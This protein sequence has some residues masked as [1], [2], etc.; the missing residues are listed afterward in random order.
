M[1]NTVN[2]ISAVD[3]EKFMDD[4]K[5]V[6]ERTEAELARTVR[7]DGV[8]AA[9]QV[10]FDIVDPTEEAEERTRD[11]KLPVSQLGLDRA[12]AFLKE[13]HKK[14]GITD[15]DAFVSNPNVRKQ[16]ASKSVISINKARDRLIYNAA[17][18]APN[19]FNGGASIVLDNFGT[20]SELVEGLWDNDVPNDGEVYGIITVRQELQLLKIE[21]FKNADYVD[22]R[23]VNEG[24]GTKRMRHF[25]GINWMTWTGID[26]RKTNAA[27]CMIYHKTALGHMGEGDPQPLAGTNEEE[28]YHWT[29]ARTRHAATV[30]LDRSILRFRAD[31]TAA[32]A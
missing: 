21:E 5:E 4:F 26:G 17:K 25:M 24:A 14:F 6:N 7:S 9:G 11:G 1:A 28:D 27:E 12:S 2:M 32:L 15:F 13:H 22:V 10:H 29:R 19:I 31:D 30:C 18:S 23:A 16:Q 20:V 3:R 8:C